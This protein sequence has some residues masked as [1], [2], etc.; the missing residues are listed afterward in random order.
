[1]KV[2]HLESGL[3][4]QMLSY[5]ELLAVR[6][7]NPD[8]EI[9]VENIVFD[10]PEANT[11]VN[12]WNGY[13]LGRVFGIKERNVS[14]LFAAEQWQQVLDEVRRREFWNHNWNYG[15]HITEALRHAGLD[16][17]N[18]C[19]DKEAP[20]ASLSIPPQHPSLA[21]RAKTYAWHHFLPLTYLR[22]YLARRQDH[23]VLANARYGF[24]FPQT[25]D[26]LYIG[27]RLDFKRKNAGIERIA[28]EVRKAF[29]FPAFT[30]PK[31]IEGA[32]L[33]SSCNAVAIHARRGDM[34]GEN[35]GLYAT[36]YF[37]R[38]V[39]YV[40]RHTTNPVFFIFTDPGSVEWCKQKAH[41]LGLDA[42]RDEIHFVDWNKGADSFRD[43]Q[44]MAVCKHQ[45]ITNSTFGW[46]AAFFN[47]HEDK[48]TCSPHAYINTTHTF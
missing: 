47:E 2:I 31:D 39:S 3:G 8:D 48:I 7:M 35:Y 16:L 5:C 13:E 28:D 25:S 17:V 38:A 37:R 29:R 46:W 44:L 42:K 33:M 1:M 22:E 40:R 27:Q 19:A 18:T 41:I 12:Q 32:R 30:N 23:R 24:L 6:K 36:G 10:M 20:G 43:M 11:V 45:V 26:H 34:L 21:Q 14:E 15:V 9:F 4:N